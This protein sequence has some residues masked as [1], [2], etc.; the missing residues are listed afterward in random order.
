M[1][2]FNGLY[3]GGRYRGKNPFGRSPASE[4]GGGGLSTE[5]VDSVTADSP[6]LWL[7]FDETSP[8]TSVLDS[9]G[10]ALHGTYEGTFPIQYARPSVTNDASTGLK[11]INNS[12]FTDGTR[13]NLSAFDNHSFWTS[14]N[15][16]VE[17]IIKPESGESLY[18]YNSTPTDDLRKTNKFHFQTSVDAYTNTLTFR[19]SAGNQTEEWVLPQSDLITPGDEYHVAVTA[20]GASPNVATVYFFVNGTKYL[21]SKRTDQDVATWQ[22]ASNVRIGGYRQ[23]PQFDGSGTWVNWYYEGTVHELIFYSSVIADATLT[24]RA[25][26]LVALTKEWDSFIFEDTPSHWFRFLATSGT[27]ETST[28]STDVLTHVNTPTLA[29]PSL[30]SS[31]DTTSIR[32]TA[33]NSE[34]SYQA[35]LPT[36]VTGNWTVEIVFKLHSVG[37]VQT[38]WMYGSKSQGDRR[39]ELLITSDNEIYLLVQNNTPTPGINFYG[40]RSVE[41]LSVDTI[42]TITVTCDGVN[43]KIYLDGA[44]VTALD[45]GTDGALALSVHTAGDEEFIVAARQQ[46]T[47]VDRYVD[48]TID[49]LILYSAEISAARALAHAGAV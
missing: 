36:G 7:R 44:D 32:Y 38:L 42:Y 16:T 22:A 8:D 19:A 27:A 28:E 13:V 25:G 29:Q 34:Y 5:W 3:A 21:G 46:S 17:A 41:T 47:T 20:T 43:T 37:V 12:A 9:S 6:D 24:A 26:Y 35:G 31:T 33:A 45:S 39:T 2:Y 18:I 4:A 40:F 48:A 49:D 30:L 11:L 23:N 10:N 1:S 14:A 15:K